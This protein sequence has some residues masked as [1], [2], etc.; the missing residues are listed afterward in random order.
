MI[1]VPLDKGK[2]LSMIF[3]SF[4]FGFP[5]PALSEVYSSEAGFDENNSNMKKKIGNLCC[6]LFK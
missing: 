5:F 4:N 3:F 2:S 1:L 6:D